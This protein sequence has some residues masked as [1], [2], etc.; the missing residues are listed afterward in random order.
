M[1]ALYCLT[2]HTQSKQTYK[3]ICRETRL[4]E[5]TFAS[6]LTQ[7]D[8]WTLESGSLKQSETKETHKIL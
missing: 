7:L 3:V 4:S 8:L 5:L 6:S 1:V 2:M